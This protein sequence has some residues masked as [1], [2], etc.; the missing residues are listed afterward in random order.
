MFVFW[1]WSFSSKH[2]KFYVNFKNAIKL[3]KNVLGFQDNCGWPSC[4][5][6]SQLWQE[7]LW[8]A[9][10]M[11]QNGTKISDPTKRHDTQLNLFDINRKLS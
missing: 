1:R 10:N 9:V 11:L 4:G 3:R 7:Y 2:S 5:N 6:F 8:S